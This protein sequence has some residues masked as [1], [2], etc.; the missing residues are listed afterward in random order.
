ME[1]LF[2]P[3]S[4]DL[5]GGR[6]FKDCVDLV[7]SRYGRGPNPTLP[8]LDPNPDENGPEMSS[9]YNQLAR[10]FNEV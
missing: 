8:Y 9:S 5:E 10:I 3:V 4:K 2:Q 1:L 6:L 7:G